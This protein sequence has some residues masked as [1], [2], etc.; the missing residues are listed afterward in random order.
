MSFSCNGCGAEL[1]GT[2][3]AG[4]CNECSVSMNE[5]LQEAEAEWFASCRKCME[6]IN[7]WGPD[8]GDKC[9]EYDMPL[10]MVKRK[11]KCKRFK[12]INYSL[13]N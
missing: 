7:A 10:D 8:P 6:C 12:E 11:K 13:I 1:N 9:S 5:G 4:Y 3:D 2:G